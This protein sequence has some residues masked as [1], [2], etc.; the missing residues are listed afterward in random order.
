MTRFHIIL[1][2][3][4]IS[5]DTVALMIVEGS[6]YHAI[7]IRDLIKQSLFISVWQTLGFIG[8][9][10]LMIWLVER[11]FNIN[12][13]QLNNWHQIISFLIFLF[14]GFLML[15][16]GLK[17]E[18]INEKREQE[19]SY[20]QTFHIAITSG[21]DALFAGAGISFLQVDTSFMSVSILWISILS[22]IIGKYIGYWFGYEEKSKVY[23]LSGVIFVTSAV[24][25]LV[26]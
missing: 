21:I 5:L 25:I 26:N 19:M 13:T 15:K 8:G 2:T 22:V 3:V 17:T 6:M 16:R 18:Y 14:L 7:K 9:N 4:A 1:L 20:R 10:W 12:S 23:I 24:Y 11:G